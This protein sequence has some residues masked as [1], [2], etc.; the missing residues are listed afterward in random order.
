MR[1]Y[2]D[3]IKARDPAARSILSIVLTYPGVKAVFFY[4]LAN[5]FYLAKF[6]L[7]ARIIS[8]TTRF[9]TGIEIHP[10]ATIGK[11]LF[12]DHGMGVVIGETSIIGDNVTIYHA[13][14]LGGISPSIDSDLQRNEKR[15]PT[16]GND[17]VIGSGAQIIGPI[18]VGKGARIA[19]NAVVVND[20]DDNST[21]VGVPAKAIRVGNKGKFRPYGV[22]QKVKDEK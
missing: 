5:F 17:V 16:I 6:D 21:M 13:V 8:Q 10:G 3:S 11:N 7:F 20:V 12:I 19:A 18:T 22:D 1:K 15:H 4:R 9:F 2:L 14:T